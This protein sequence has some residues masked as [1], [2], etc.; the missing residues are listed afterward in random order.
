VG[1]RERERERRV[2][3]RDLS[4]PVVA[5]SRNLRS[6]SAAAVAPAILIRTGNVRAF[7]CSVSVSRITTG[8]SDA[9]RL[10]RVRANFAIRRE[11]AA[12][13]FRGPIEPSSPEVSSG[14]EPLHVLQVLCAQLCA[15]YG[16]SVFALPIY[17]AYYYSIDTENSK[18]Q[19]L[20]SL[21]PSLSPPHPTPAHP[22][23]QP[24]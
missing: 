19:H 12:F 22:S 14:G 23:Q 18:V 6:I 24:K 8:K 5:P 10:S 11:R 20:V 7:P 21:S 4:E 2:G 1:E 16:A 3:V 15:A 13:Y 9:Y 17:P